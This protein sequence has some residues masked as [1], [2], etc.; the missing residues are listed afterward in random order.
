MTKYVRHV[1][2]SRIEVRNVERGQWS[3]GKNKQNKSS[4]K[5]ISEMLFF[6]GTVMPARVLKYPDACNVVCGQYDK[7]RVLAPLATL[8]TSS[9]P[10]FYFFSSYL[11]S[12][13]FHPL[14]QMVG[15]F[16][17]P[18]FKVSVHTSLRHS[19][20]TESMNLEWKSWMVKEEP[21]GNEDGHVKPIAYSEGLPP[22]LNLDCN[23][24]WFKPSKII[25]FR[26]KIEPYFIFTWRWKIYNPVLLKV[27]WTGQIWKI[28]QQKNFTIRNI[29]YLITVLLYKIIKL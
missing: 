5:L 28:S 16:W 26:L 8:L 3:G 20:G 24:A 7:P 22:K 27:E 18:L 14:P 9:V 6:G 2:K 25:L 15:G 1:I 13:F 12:H 17:F 19:I 21:I 23:I 10:P 11:L 29:D 4:Q